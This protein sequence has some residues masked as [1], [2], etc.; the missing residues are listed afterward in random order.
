LTWI[1]IAISFFIHPE[2]CILKALFVTAEN[3]CMNYFMKQVV[4]HTIGSYYDIDM[5]NKND[6]KLELIMRLE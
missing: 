3:V 4:H 2:T 5:K 1:S 6:L